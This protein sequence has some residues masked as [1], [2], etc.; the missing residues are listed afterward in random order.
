MTS[1][2]AE[3]QHLNGDGRF[4]ADFSTDSAVATYAGDLRSD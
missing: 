2:H 1:R 3:Y 4:S